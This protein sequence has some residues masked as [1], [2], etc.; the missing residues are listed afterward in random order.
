MKHRLL[1]IYYL[2][3]AVF[4][5]ASEDIAPITSSAPAPEGAVVKEQLPEKTPA[6]EEGLA[7]WYAGK[8][9]GRYTASGEIFDT[10]QLTAAHKSLPFGTLVK[11]TNLE[12]TLSVIVRINDRGPFVEGRIIDLSRKAAAQI[13]LSA[14][15]IVK[16]RLDIVGKVE[17][18]FIYTIQLGAY[19]EEENALAVQKRLQPH[20]LA[21]ILEKTTTGY[22]RVLLKQ[23]TRN[24]A[25]QAQALLKKLGFKNYL[26]KKEISLEFPDT[27][28]IR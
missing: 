20:Q 22:T 28:M 27:P 17:Y 12:N 2:I 25:E 19:A 23:L 13:G 6:S 5:L 14:Q 11:V 26:V 8:F 7:S 21:V 15:G 9:Q 4:N 3:L 18:T 16:V 10:N 24:E 1:I